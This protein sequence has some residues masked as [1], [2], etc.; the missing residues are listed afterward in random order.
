MGTERSRKRAF[1]IRILVLGMIVFGLVGCRR[2]PGQVSE[3]F[4]ITINTWVGFAPLYLA[5]EKE[6]F[7]QHG[8]KQVEIVKIDDVGAR[9]ASM[10]A[11]RIEGYA[12]SVDNW[13]LDSAQ[14]VT[15]KIVIAFD[16]S[17]GG[18]GIVAKKSITQLADLR[19]KTIGVQP[20]MPGQF[21]LFHLLSEAGLTSEDVKTVDMDSDKAGAAFVGGKLDAA[22]TWEPWL[23]K[24]ASAEG[25]VLV[26]TKD[27]P[28]LI[29]DVL[30][31][32][33]DVLK[34]RPGDVIAVMKAWCDALDYWKTHKDESAEIMAKALG[35]PS[36]DFSAMC[37][38]VRHFGLA[39]N[40]SYFGT[41]SNPGPIYSVFDSAGQIWAA[42]GIIETPTKALDAIHPGLLEQIR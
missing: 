38:G 2:Q 28:G 10:K 29:V 35:L 30:V 4:R 24:A 15:G 13:A 27:N 25:H 12:S 16:E 5:Q 40:R 9:K 34:D 14:G 23:S 21:L 18:D 36:A 31:A 6:M 32:P 26:S 20:G 19:G 17:H 1:L 11:G 8:L 37:E 41:T 42:Q 33:E 22:V 7:G 3:P 39:E